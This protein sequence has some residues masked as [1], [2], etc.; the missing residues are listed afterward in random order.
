MRAHERTNLIKSGMFVAMASIVSMVI[1]ITLGKESSMFSKM[2]EI[3]IKAQDAKNLRPGAK[4]KL[5]GIKI[6]K[7]S[8]ITFED[9]E[10]IVINLEVEKSY[11][12]IIRTNTKASIQTQ[13]MLGDKYLELYGG[14]V[15]NPPV[16]QG[17]FLEL[18]EQLE[19]NKFISKGDNILELSMSV[20]GKIDL[21][22]DQVN[23]DQNVSKTLA[24]VT[25]STEK[26]EKIL[27][28][29]EGKK[30]NRII[31][32]FDQMGTRINSG[33]GTLYSLLYDQSAYEELRTL[34][35]GAQRNKLLKYFIRESIK[36]TEKV[37][38]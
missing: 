20:L 4:V 15:E 37:T 14:S 24:S 23:G 29:I 18:K 10:N 30:V 9:I 35:G 26:L 28:Q 8:N 34:L 7:V 22:L 33:P 2:L 5:K 19:L 3:K 31:Q 13:G 6:G 32:N 36:D 27:D 11:R 17:D 12:D 1:I 25:S 16:K 38:D 21:F